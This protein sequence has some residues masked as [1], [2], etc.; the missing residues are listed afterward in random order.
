MYSNVK[1]EITI[2]QDETERFMQPVNKCTE[3]MTKE[4]FIL[5]NADLSNNDY[6]V[7]KRIWRL[8]KTRRKNIN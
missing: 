2:S 1:K 6:S 4:E 5:V 8:R 7:Q 3:T